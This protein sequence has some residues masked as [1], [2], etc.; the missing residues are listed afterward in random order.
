[1]DLIQHRFDDAQNRLENSDEKNFR[2]EQ[3]RIQ[4]L[5]HML[6]IED[7]AK[8]VLDKARTPSGLSAIN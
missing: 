7:T 2:F 3:G 8:A 6:E 5:R 4:E 1:M